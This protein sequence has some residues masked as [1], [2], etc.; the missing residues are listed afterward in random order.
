MKK[1]L[2]IMNPCAG[3]RRA[4]RYLPEMI[5]LFTKHGYENTVYMTACRGDGTRIAMERGGDVDLVV[6]VGGDGTFN[7]VATGLLQAGLQRPVGYIPAGSTNDFASSLHLP[8]QIMEAAAV[9]VEGKAQPFDIGRFEDRYFSYVASFGAFTK[10]SYSTPQNVKNA[11]GHLAYIL[12]GIKDIGSIRPEHLRIETEEQ[13]FEGDYIFG[14]ISNTTSVGGVLTLDPD[15]VDLHDGKFEL[16]LIRSPKDLLELNACVAAL[17]GRHY[18]S[19]MITFAS[20]S[21]LQIT[22]NPEMDWTL[23]GERAEGRAELTIENLQG[24]VSLVVRPEQN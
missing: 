12:A 15:M 3:T 10:T 1:L 24:A 22:A 9:V 16:L 21:R 20:A 4:N 6:C 14:A 13:V 11:L 7:E 23:D 17:I 2:L 19:K 5:A 18:H 8:K